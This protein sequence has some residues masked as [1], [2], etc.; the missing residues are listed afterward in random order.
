MYVPELYAWRSAV[1]PMLSPR[2]MQAVQDRWL[3]EQGEAIRLLLVS[4][5]WPHLRFA[6]VQ[7]GRGSRGLL[8]GS[9]RRQPLQSG[10]LQP[11][12]VPKT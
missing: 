4:R 8:L 7:Q 10:R 12:V 3:Y 1:Q 2:R 5:W 6:R 9:W 11:T